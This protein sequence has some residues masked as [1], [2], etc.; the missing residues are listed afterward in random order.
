MCWQT[1]FYEDGEAGAQ[2]YQ[3]TFSLLAMTTYPN[4]G[5]YDPE[6]A[7]TDFD[8]LLEG[9]TDSA[10]AATAMAT[11]GEDVPGSHRSGYAGPAHPQ[12]RRGGRGVRQGDGSHYDGAG[13]PRHAGGLRRTQRGCA[14]TTR[15]S[16]PR[17][18]VKALLTSSWGPRHPAFDSDGAWQPPEQDVEAQSARYVYVGGEE[19]WRDIQAGTPMADADGDGTPD[20]WRLLP[21]TGRVSEI[22][23]RP[24][25]ARGGRDAGF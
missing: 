19:T 12:H 5:V 9:A 2:R 16:R 21:D 11:G 3:Q 10:A 6:S 1:N 23:G 14:A 24:L 18:F 25:Q 13:F 20:G 15:Q 7:W 22:G 17:C 4:G 8:T